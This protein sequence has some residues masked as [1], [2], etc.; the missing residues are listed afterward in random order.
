MEPSARYEEVK[1][2]LPTPVHGLEVV[3]GMLGIPEWWPSGARV[4]VVIAPGQ[5]GAKGD[6]LVEEVHRQLTVRKYLS[7]RFNFPYREAG[8][9][10]P[11]P[12]PVLEQTFRAAVALLGADPT[13]APAHVFV[14]GAGV[15]A[16]VATHVANARLH[17]D[18]VFAL[19]Y[20]LHP[21]GKPDEVHADQLFRIIAPMLF[22]QG[23]RSR[24][25]DLGVLRKTL[26]R[27]GA[28][29]SLQTVEEADH[30]FA[31]LK[32]SGRDPEEVRDEILNGL[33]GWFEKV[34]GLS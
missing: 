8:K 26:L 34:L 13:S 18:G 27:V 32:K 15:G 30:V 33:E 11:D 20:P 22:I 7:L 5:G 12:M 31:V 17:V 14:G 1:I 19:G 2:A 6:P 21:V 10:R 25:C 29:T 3:S 24:N 9:R 28:P 23:S 16:Q 4:G